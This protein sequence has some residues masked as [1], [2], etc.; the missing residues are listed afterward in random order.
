M[1]SHQLHLHSSSDTFLAYLLHVS[2]VLIEEE[3]YS[4]CVFIVLLEVRHMKVLDSVIIIDLI[5]NIYIY[6]FDAL[7]LFVDSI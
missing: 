7:F 6:I 3:Q 4:G 1:K 2:Y 5:K